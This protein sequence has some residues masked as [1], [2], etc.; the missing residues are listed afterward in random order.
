MTPGP[1]PLGTGTGRLLN[2]DPVDSRPFAGATAFLHIDYKPQFFWWEV[3][4]HKLNLTT[5][6]LVAAYAR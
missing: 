3:I 6:C 1:L 2:A 5:C 4:S